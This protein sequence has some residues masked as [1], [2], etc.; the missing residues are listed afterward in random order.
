LFIDERESMMEYSR[1][2]YM[3]GMGVT[4]SRIHS[5]ISTHDKHE[6]VTLLCTVQLKV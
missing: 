6:C 1:H 3:E 5:P 4:V 2:I